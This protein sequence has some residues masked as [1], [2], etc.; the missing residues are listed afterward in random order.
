MSKGR[1]VYVDDDLEL[2]RLLQITLED[3]GY[4]VFVANEGEEGLGT[5]LEEQPD[6]VIL[7][8]MM[9]NMDGFELVNAVR[10]D[11]AFQDLLFIGLSA[12]GN[13]MLSA[14]FIKSGAN[15]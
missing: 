6:L 8:I 1:I 3:E 4:E 2:T 10:K 9:P 7:D 15:R 13:S 5:I 11:S 14:K 12:N